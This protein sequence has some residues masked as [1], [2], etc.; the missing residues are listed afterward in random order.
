MVLGPA[1]KN[2]QGKT[3]WICECDCGTK[4]N[5]TTNSLR[6]GNST[7]CGCN[8]CPDLVDQTFDDITVLSL[9]DC[10]KNNRRNWLC[11]CKCG[12]ALILTTYQ[13]RS[14][15]KKC[16]CKNII[17]QTV[18][19]PLLEYKMEIIKNSCKKVLDETARLMELLKN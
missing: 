18:D 17:Q 6:T 12:K 13:L 16:D 19:I 11:K 10:K 15:I 14:D 9:S 4:R 8:H 1:G 5:I 3:Q 7:S 2:G